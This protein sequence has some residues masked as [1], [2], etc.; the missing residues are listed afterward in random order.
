MDSEKTGSIFIKKSHQKD[1]WQHTIAHTTRNK[2]HYHN[3]IQKKLKK[4]WSVS[5][6]YVLLQPLLREKKGVRL[7]QYNS[8]FQLATVNRKL[9]YGVTV[10]HLTLDQLV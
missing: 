8:H 1:I 5:E 3:N 2:I 7:A 9:S 10:A 4:I 6:K